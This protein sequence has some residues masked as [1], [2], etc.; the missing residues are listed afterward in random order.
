MRR[1]AL[2]ASTVWRYADEATRARL[3]Q[4]VSP[5]GMRKRLRATRAMI[6][7][8]GSSGRA[9]HL[10]RD[11]LRLWTLLGR[12]TTS[13]DQTCDSCATGWTTP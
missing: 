8:P 13:S 2:D 1:G 5:E 12:R 4:A 9:E 11:P 10:V 6:L 3:E 7:A